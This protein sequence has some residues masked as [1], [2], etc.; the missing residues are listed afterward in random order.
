MIDSNIRR[1]PAYAGDP[2]TNN[3]Y[4]M[5]AN[6]A[7]AKLKMSGTKILSI[8][9]LYRSE[10]LPV[11]TCSD[12][13]FVVCYELE[14]W[15]AKRCVPKCR[16]DL[17][18][19]EAVLKTTVTQALA[20]SWQLSLND[21]YW[22]TDDTEISWG[23]I[24]FIDNGF[25]NFFAN[26]FLFG[27]DW[28]KNYNIPDL[29]TN[30]IYE[31]AWVMKNGVA[32][33]IKA[34]DPETSDQ[35]CANEVAAY[36]I[37][38]LMN[39]DCAKYLPAPIGDQMF[40]ASENFIRSSDEEFVTGDQIM[41]SL[42]KKPMS[43]YAWLCENGFKV[44]TDRMLAF[45]H[46]IGNDDRHLLNF[47]VIRSVSTLETKRFAPLFDSGNCLD[48]NRAEN[49]D[50]AFC[51]QP[52]NRNREQQLSMI[53]MQN[54]CLPDPAQVKYIIRNVYE[55]FG[56][57]DHRLD[58]ACAMIDKGYAE[59]EYLAEKQYTKEEQEHDER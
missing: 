41:R 26:A 13:D 47:G 50:M 20:Q 4:L 39:I 12:R 56:I 42:D 16:F 23:Q 3:I 5:H 1:S 51:A 25:E 22:F 54:V 35:Q 31:K 33:L 14:S 55:K 34:G 10:L 2:L 17:D 8:E 29:V 18:R 53:D 6:D 44:E 43:V 46:L 11:G 32:W 59:L 57:T 19:L 28:K 58:R 49:A 45:D 27:S 48:Y 40:C 38:S 52:F 21:A 9:E 24:N 7:V 30:G 36:R 37:A 15:M